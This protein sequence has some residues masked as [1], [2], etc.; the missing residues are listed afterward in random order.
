MH[1]Q[2]MDIYDIYKKVLKQKHTRL[3]VETEIPYHTLMKYVR[4]ERES[5]MHHEEIIREV[6]S[7]EL[8]KQIKNHETKAKELSKLREIIK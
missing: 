1:R 6:I 8:E 4:A 3:S 7:E 5:P 2:L